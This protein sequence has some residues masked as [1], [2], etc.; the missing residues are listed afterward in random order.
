LRLVVTTP[1]AIVLEAEAV[2][3][4]RAED[5][6]GS[7]TILP[8]HA[9]FLVVLVVSVLGWR[10]ADGVERH[11]AVRSG[12]LTVRD[13]REVSVATRQAVAEETLGGLGPAVLAR[14]RAEEAAERSARTEAMRLELAAWRRLERYL[15]VGRGAGRRASPALLDG[16]HEPWPEGE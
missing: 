10:A 8:G 16:A 5:A 1:Q 13:G 2:R 3:A 11:V 14:L 7:F 12:I 6:T 4:V 15:A 9:D